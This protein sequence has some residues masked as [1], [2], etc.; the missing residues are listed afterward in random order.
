MHLC[1]GKTY[2]ETN[3][4][5]N[6]KKH[7]KR[8]QWYIFSIQQN[9]LSVKNTTIKCGIDRA[10]SRMFGP[11]LATLYS[12]CSIPSFAWNSSPEITLAVINVVCGVCIWVGCTVKVTVFAGR[13][14][15]GTTFCEVTTMPCEMA[16]AVAL[17]TCCEKSCGVETTLLDVAWDF[18]SPESKFDA[19]KFC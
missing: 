15:A 19:T 2:S 10:L 3:N 16:A 13:V 8:V 11:K 4:K 12:F 1:R 6:K 17:A 18:T 9:I 5:R 14:G 7:W